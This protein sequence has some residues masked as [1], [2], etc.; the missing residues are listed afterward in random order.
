MIHTFTVV[1]RQFVDGLEPPY[2]VAMVELDEAPG[3]RLI[4]NIVG[5]APDDVR[6]GAAVRGVFQ[7]LDAEVGLLDFELVRDE[8]SVA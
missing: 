7:V 3:V 8:S 2:V 4:A 1:G 5:S 6:I